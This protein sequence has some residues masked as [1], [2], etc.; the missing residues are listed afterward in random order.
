MKKWSRIGIAAVVAVI[1]LA[2]CAKM[3]DEKLMVKGKQLE[4]EQKFTEAIAS[5]QKLMTNSRQAPWFG[6]H[7]SESPGSCKCASRV[8]H[9]RFRTDG[10]S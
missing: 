4:S 10:G 5:Y 9:R 7:V 8:R 6:S 3:P 1:M 2:G